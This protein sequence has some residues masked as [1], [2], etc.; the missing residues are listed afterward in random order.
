MLVSTYKVSSCKIFVGLC[1]KNAPEQSLES[2]KSGSA[3]LGLVVLSSLDEEI[4][5]TLENSDFLSRLLRTKFQ[6]RTRGTASNPW[7]WTASN[8]WDYFKPVGSWDCSPIVI[9]V[10]RGGSGHDFNLI[11]PWSYL[12]VCRT[13][14]RKLHLLD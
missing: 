10:V 11:I 9:I 4:A 8:L 2:Y 13:Y 14:C 3:T 1:Q 7:D 5:G 12:Y 6:Y